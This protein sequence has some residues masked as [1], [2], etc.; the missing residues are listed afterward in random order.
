[1][2]ICNNPILCPGGSCIGCKDGKLD[3]TDPR[4]YPN[5][6]GCNITTNNTN[7][8]RIL[9]IIVLIL[10]I[11][12]GIIL[13]V[14]IF[15]SR[16]CIDMNDMNENDDM[17]DMNENSD[18]NDMNMNENSDMNDINMNENDINSQLNYS[19]NP[20]NLVYTNDENNINIK[21]PCIK[22]FRV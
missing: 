18:M 1:M 20:N 4:C 9:L 10:L 12:L 8:N 17:N 16:H 13:I 14:I 7:W 3:C 2:D 19:V 5:C 21:K 6:T 15:N 22:V 11:I